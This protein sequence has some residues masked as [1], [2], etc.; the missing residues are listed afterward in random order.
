MSY[1]ARYRCSCNAAQAETEGQKP[2]LQAV[3]EIRGA[4]SHRDSSQCV[5]KQLF[6][7]RPASCTVRAGPGPRQPKPQEEGDVLRAWK[8]T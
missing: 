8:P 3:P 4:S 5:L 1:M 2:C 7:S 6:D